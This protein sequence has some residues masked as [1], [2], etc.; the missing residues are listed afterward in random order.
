MHPI[1]TYCPPEKQVALLRLLMHV[2]HKGG[3]IIAKGAP[4]GRIQNEVDVWPELIRA[5]A[6]VRNDDLSPL[7]ELRNR[8][9]RQ[10]DRIERDYVA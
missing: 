8:I 5:K 2:F 6:N 10:L 1:D 3:E 7:E 4:V 9:D